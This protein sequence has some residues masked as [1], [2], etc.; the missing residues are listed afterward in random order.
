MGRF[1]FWVTCADDSP[2]TSD[3]TTRAA[4]FN[5]EFTLEKWLED[6]PFLLGPVAPHGASC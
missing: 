6:D 2:T 5:G 3:S 1:P 4:K